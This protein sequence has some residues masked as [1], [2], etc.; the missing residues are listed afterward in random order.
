MAIDYSVL[1]LSK[2]PPRVLIERAQKNAEDKAWRLTCKSVD[3]RDKFVCQV[4]GRVVKPGA[5][6]AWQALE[7]HHLEPRSKNKLRKFTFN[8]VLTVSR[9]VHQLIHSGALKLL[10]RAGRP[11]K[12]VREIDHVAWNRRLVPAGEEPCR[13]RKGL[14]VRK[15]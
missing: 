1:S 14:A 9:A 4:T 2:G 6:D 5:V 13:I 11:A 3:A 15:D 8:N 12:D 7:R 10:N